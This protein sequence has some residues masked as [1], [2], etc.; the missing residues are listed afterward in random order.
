MPD[1]TLTYYG[2]VKDGKIILPRTK[3]QKEVV[4]AFEG[5]Q[6]EVTWK[7]K[8]KTR[9]L[10]QLRYYFGVCVKTISEYLKDFAPEQD[11]SKDVVHQF[12]KEKF[13]PLVLE[14]KPF[15]ILPTGERVQGI[16]S[17][18]KLTTTQFMDY[19]ARIHHWAA[20]L[21]IYIADPEEKWEDQ[22]INIDKK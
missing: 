3:V 9:T 8:K 2:R 7:R 22:T 16:Y 5:R 15:L 17:T 20:E 12:L 6:I 14:E 10:P 1:Q 13:L 11:A 21:G 18:T 4:Q 19:I